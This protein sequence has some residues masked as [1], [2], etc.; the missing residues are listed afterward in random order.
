MWTPI[1]SPIY[2]D[3]K[4]LLAAWREGLLAQK[5]LHTWVKGDT[6]GYINHSQLNRFKQCDEPLTAIASYLWCIVVEARR[7]HYSFDHTKINIENTKIGY[8]CLPVTR[9]EIAHEWGHLQS[10]LWVRS[11]E[12]F[13]WN[14]EVRAKD[15]E[16][17]LNFAFHEE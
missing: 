1:I 5:C 4:G 17:K 8:A 15:E 11:P 13:Q 2:L 12:K 10:K 16:I 3:T 6:C 9:E 14:E 7:R